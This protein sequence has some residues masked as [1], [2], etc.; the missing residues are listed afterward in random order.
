VAR[1]AWQLFGNDAV[2]TPLAWPRMRNEVTS[3]KVV[4]ENTVCLNTG[5]A[6]ILL[7]IRHILKSIAGGDV[8]FFVFDSQPEV[9]AR[10]YPKKDY[11]DLEFHKLLSESL[12]RD[13]HSGGIKGRLK[14]IYN[15]GVFRALRRFAQN[16]AASSVFFSPS[17]R[18]GLDAYASAD[19][20][21][22][23]GGTYLVENYDLEKRLNQFRI[24]AIL[25]KDPIFFTQSLGPFKKS[26]NRQ[27]LGPI[28]DRSPLILLRDE[29]SRNHMLDLVKDPGKC[30]VVA[31]A[32]FALADTDRI[33]KHLDSAPAPTGRV[34]ISV[35]H[36]S[37]VSDGEDGMRRYLDS[38]R[39]IATI[40]VRDHA[41][42]VTFVSTCQGVPE[43]AH[44]DA[45]TARAIVA[46]LDPDIAKHV[47][48]DA[49]FHT[50]D[51]LMALVKGCDFVV[52][53]RMHMM[54]M[55]LCVGTPVLPIAYEFKTKEVAKRI[56]VADLLLDID[57]VTPSEAAEKLGG[58]IGSLD[59]YRR[60]SLAAV[61]EEH[62]SAMSATRQLS[63]LIGNRL[64]N[65]AGDVG[66]S[67]EQ[68]L[69]RLRNSKHEGQGEP[70]V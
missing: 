62:A 34:A 45:R 4:V 18:R 66:K 5:D 63:S 3:M 26:Y 12:F 10:L 47:S 29:R 61:L 27:E 69:A 56:G 64:P 70:V 1:I 6:A 20:V 46:E 7:A 67:G 31:D 59:R 55:S 35:R 13:Q 19:M 9:A 24:D 36:W 40:L 52:A 28:F 60:A 2:L 44:D 42:E 21:V 11:P 53:T 8:Q 57:T 16:G 58:F 43:Y 30:H 41:K 39:E 38:I 22:T 25:G 51:Q 50:P 48:V 32:V 65:V 68:R 54:I 37:F 23:T 14:S 17:D 33:K 49:S 15:W